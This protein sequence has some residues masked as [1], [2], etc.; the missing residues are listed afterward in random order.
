[1]CPGRGSRV[2]SNQLLLMLILPPFPFSQFLSPKTN[3][4]TD[5]FGGSPEGRREY[6]VRCLKEIR[7]RCGPK[8]IV[9]VKLNSAD[10]TSGGLTSEESISHIRALR[11]LGIDFVEISGGTYESGA[12]YGAEAR[13]KQSQKKESTIKREAYFLEFA[14][15][16]RHEVP[17]IC[18]MV[19]GGFRSRVGMGQALRSG[20]CDLIGLGRPACIDPDLPLRILETPDNVQDVRCVEY[21]HE[22]NVKDKRARGTD[23][24]AHTAQMRRIALGLEP[25]P[26]MDV[27]DLL[28][29]GKGDWLHLT[30]VYGKPT[31]N[32]TWKL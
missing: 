5:E 14:E 6:L 10:F 23:V 28:A 7:K 15:Q 24:M 17:D 11:D 18:L 31:A 2:L 1:M 13:H 27:V 21:D 9:G 4:R 8:F 22:K 3:K 25:D 29:D 12:F 32:G 16:C 20:A 26:N 30:R 19:T